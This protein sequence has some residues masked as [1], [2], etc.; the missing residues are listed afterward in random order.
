MRRHA[1]IPLIAARLT[2]LVLAPAASVTEFTCEPPA[3]TV[4]DRL[5]VP[6][7]A[8]TPKMPRMPGMPD[9]AGATMTMKQ[10]W[11][12]RRTGECR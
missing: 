2:C 9:M 11:K 3:P 7:V 12:A 1:R 5:A 8:Q 4:F 10:T 6:G